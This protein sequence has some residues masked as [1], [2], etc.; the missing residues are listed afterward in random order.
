[1]FLAGSLGA[2]N[3]G[4]GLRGGGGAHGGNLHRKAE[5]AAK[6]CPAP[7]SNWEHAWHRKNAQQKTT[8]EISRHHCSPKPG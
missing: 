6:A 7:S 4:R 3:V 1:M 5:Q 8:G 2:R